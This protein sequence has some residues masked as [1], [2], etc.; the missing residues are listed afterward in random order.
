MAIVLAGGYALNIQ[1]TVDIQVNTCK[2]ALGIKE[3]V[4]TPES[5]PENKKETKPNQ[6]EPA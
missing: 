5:K 2:V 6:P 1:D 4:I 3:P